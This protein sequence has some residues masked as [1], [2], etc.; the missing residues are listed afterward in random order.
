MNGLHYMTSSRF[1]QDV[2]TRIRH[3]LAQLAH[4]LLS[5]QT[6]ELP[7]AQPEKGAL[8]A[9]AHESASVRQYNDHTALIFTL[10][11][12]FMLAG[13]AQFISL[14]AYAN[15]N[16]WQ[17]GCGESAFFRVYVYPVLPRA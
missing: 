5:T 11:L 4:R 15:R 9:D 14:L 12:C 17:T 10:N 7:T 16:G 8:P 1:F 13:L 6:L 3:A 2:L